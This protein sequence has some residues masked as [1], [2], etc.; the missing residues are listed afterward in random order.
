MAGCGDTGS[1]HGQWRDSWG[2]VVSGASGGPSRDRRA[3]CAEEEW[4]VARGSMA[5]WLG[6]GCRRG[7]QRVGSSRSGGAKR[8]GWSAGEERLGE[9]GRRGRDGQGW[10]VGRA[11]VA[12]GLPRLVSGN[13]GVVCMVQEWNVAREARARGASG[14]RGARGV[15]RVELSKSDRAGMVCRQGWP[16]DGKSG[17]HSDAAAWLVG[18]FAV[19]GVA[20]V[21]R[22]ARVEGVRNG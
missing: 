17:R 2:W 6:M 13:L 22:W 19:L 14:C 16:G 18:W 10:V 11:C 9:G 20:K 7:Q 21:C 4:V 15:T 5:R 8:L 1:R 12:I 3:V